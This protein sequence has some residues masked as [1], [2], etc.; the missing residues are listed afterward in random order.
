MAPLE[1]HMRR[2]TGE[3][4]YPCTQ[5][6]KRFVDSTALRKHM[7]IHDDVKD[8]HVCGTCGKNFSDK[9]NLAKHM[10]IHKPGDETK[11]TVWN[12]IRDVSAETEQVNF[13]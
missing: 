1:I 13:L 5:C 2:H 12:I 10:K 9:S 8:L 3:K 7:H 11:N 6:K 4:P